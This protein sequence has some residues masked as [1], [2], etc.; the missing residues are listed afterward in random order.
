M[1]VTEK[2]LRVYMVDRQLAGLKGRLSGSQRFL[3]EQSRQLGSLS[4]EHSTVS[5]K[6]KKLEASIANQEGEVASLDER[7]RDARRRQRI[8][9]RAHREKT[10]LRVTHTTTD[11]RTRALDARLNA[12][13]APNPSCFFT[14]VVDARTTER[15]NDRTDRRLPTDAAS[16]TVPEEAL[17]TEA[18]F[19][20]QRVH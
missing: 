15:P 9:R 10:S 19:R 3:D 13:R 11:T 17:S 1:T 6:L 5:T 4:E 20:F 14:F 18:A 12:P 2:L 8:A 16:A 7:I